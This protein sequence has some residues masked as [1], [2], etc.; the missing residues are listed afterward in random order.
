MTHSTLTE[1]ALVPLFPSCSIWNTIG[2]ACLINLI[3][4][5]WEFT[6]YTEQMAGSSSTRASDVKCGTL[7]TPRSNDLTDQIAVWSDS[8]LGHQGAKTENTECYNSWTNGW[9]ISKFL[10]WVHL[11]R[12]HDIIPGFFIWPTFQGHRGQSSCGSVKSAQIKHHVSTWSMDHFIWCCKRHVGGNWRNNIQLSRGVMLQLTFHIWFANHETSWFPLSVNLPSFIFMRNKVLLWVWN[13]LQTLFPSRDVI[14]VTFAT[15]FKHN[16]I[17]F[18]F[19]KMKKEEHHKLGDIQCCELQSKWI[20]YRAA[21]IICDC[22]I[23][24]KRYWI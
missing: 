4:F 3:C 15:T 10:S 14:L 7:C 2:L 24:C 21:L 9:I 11:I 1:G 18:M 13:L 8:W 12:I 22:L 16:L 19:V 6:K 23:P 17:L 20:W 5:L